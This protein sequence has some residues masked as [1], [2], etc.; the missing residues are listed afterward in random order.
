MRL[1]LRFCLLLLVLLSAET[2][3]WMEGVKFA[4]I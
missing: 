2:H 3:A 4:Y 1:S